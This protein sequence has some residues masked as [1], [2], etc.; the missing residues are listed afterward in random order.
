MYEKAIGV[1]ERG[2]DGRVREK[3]VT[4]RYWGG[5]AKGMRKL[6]IQAIATS[7]SERSS[8]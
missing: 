1:V 7:R 4:K 6:Y 3:A 5:P 8:F 2:L